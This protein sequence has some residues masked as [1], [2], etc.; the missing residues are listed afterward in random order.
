MT[1]ESMLHLQEEASLQV[2][3]IIR[4]PCE[5]SREAPCPEEMTGVVN[6]VAESIKVRR[7]P[8]LIPDVNNITMMITLVVVEELAT[9]AA[10]EEVLSKVILEV[11]QVANLTGMRSLI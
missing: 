11:V 7:Q 1:A 2:G 6:G 3:T 9:E 8:P 4:P 5:D 10:V